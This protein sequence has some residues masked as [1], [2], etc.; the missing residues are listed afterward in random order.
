MSQTGKW[1]T[2][3]YKV[4]QHHSSSGKYKSRPTVR[5]HLIT[6]RMA[7]IKIKITSSGE[8][9]E[10]MEPWCSVDGN[11]HCYSHYGKQHGVSSKS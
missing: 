8:G 10:K 1:P 7:I 11:V 2:G 4:A 9:M 6:V 3:T 5:Y